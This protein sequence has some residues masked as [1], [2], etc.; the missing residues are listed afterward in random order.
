MHE[1][2][3]INDFTHNRQTVRN[4]DKVRIAAADV[5]TFELRGLIEPGSAV[6]VDDATEDDDEREHVA[7]TTQASAGT[8]LAGGEKAEQGIQNKMEPANANK[9]VPVKPAN[10]PAKTANAAKRS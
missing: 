9:T 2:I 5:N 7:K 3:A 4:G 8:S 1:A 6:E 10:V